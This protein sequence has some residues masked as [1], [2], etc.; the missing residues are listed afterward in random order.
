[1]KNLNLIKTRHLTLAYFENIRK[2]M[3]DQ[4]MVKN[5]Y[6]IMILDLKEKRN[7]FLYSS[8]NC[9][10]SHLTNKL[11]SKLVA[12]KGILIKSPDW[13]RFLGETLNIVVGLYL[14]A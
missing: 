9:C 7:S 1:M 14:S 4:M 3:F 6:S 8:N 12:Y 2:I 5:N 11:A 10:W 13:V